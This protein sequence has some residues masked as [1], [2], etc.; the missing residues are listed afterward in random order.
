MFLLIAQV[1][2]ILY[3]RNNGPF[4]QSNTFSRYPYQMAYAYDRVQ[5]SSLIG[6]VMG[7]LAFSFLFAFI[8]TLVGSFIIH[9]VATYWIVA[10]GGLGVLSCCSARKVHAI[11]DWHRRTVIELED[12]AA[13]F[14]AQF[15]FLHIY[16][17]FLKKP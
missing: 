3:S 9:G 2:C 12:E 6:K 16:L 15:W 7:L 8:G 17:H 5:T 14:V 4:G 11:N 13:A 1:R 10:L